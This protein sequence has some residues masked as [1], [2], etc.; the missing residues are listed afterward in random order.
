MV[1]T[2]II[3][4]DNVSS[5]KAHCTSTPPE[6]IHCASGTTCGCSSARTCGNCAIPSAAE[7]SMAPQV[8]SCAPRS[9]I[10]RPRK[11]EIAA[12][13]RGR[14]TTKTTTRLAPHHMD[15]G[16]LDRAAIAEIDDEDGEPDC[17]LG[18]CDR[19]YEHRED[20]ADQIMQDDRKGDEVDVDRKQHQLD[21]H[22]DDDDV[23]AVQKDAE[24]TE[25][26]QDR[27]DRQVMRETDCHRLSLRRRAEPAVAPPRLRRERRSRPAP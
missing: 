14:K 24:D 7:S 22:H 12:A 23:L 11:P 25:R 5:R 18:G 2:R 19:Q 3:T 17:R 21:R 1:T 8:T 16:N 20:L 10:A 9:P 15:V 4:P 26:K 13:S 27:R 6:T